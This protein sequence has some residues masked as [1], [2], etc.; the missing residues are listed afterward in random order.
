MLSDTFAVEM[1]LAGVTLE[2]VSVLLGHSRSNSN[3]RW[4]GGGQRTHSM[5]CPQPRRQNLF[6]RFLP[7]IRE[8]ITNKIVLR[9]QLASP[10]HSSHCPHVLKAN[11]A[12]SHTGFLSTFLRH[13]KPNSGALCLW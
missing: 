7:S 6:S 3:G 4:P 10:T 5:P 2:K 8:A 11:A 12:R 13:R 1:L 9:P